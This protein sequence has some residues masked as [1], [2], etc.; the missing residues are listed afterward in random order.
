CAELDAL[1]EIR[2]TDKDLFRELQEFRRS[3]SPECRAAEMRRLCA[4]RPRRPATD[5][6]QAW[7][8]LFEAEPPLPL[9]Q[10][11]AADV[12]GAP[13]AAEIV[14]RELEPQKPKGRRGRRPGYPRAVEMAI[15]LM[16][17]DKLSPSGIYKMC[18]QECGQKY[19]EKL[20]KQ[21]SFF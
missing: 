11:P 17:E 10:G 13:E 2:E 4:E 8:W 5:L 15:R 18:K 3:L 20:P 14:L 16:D 7:R 12:L 19:N 6:A 21:E 1:P 9:R